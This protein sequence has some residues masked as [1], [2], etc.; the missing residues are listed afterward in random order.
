MFSRSLPRWPFAALALLQMVGLYVMSAQPPDLA[1]RMAP[2]PLGNLLHLPI[3]FI[4]A[5]LVLRAFAPRGKLF[6]EGVWPG[7]RTGA[8]R[9]CLLVVLAHAVFDEVHQFFVGRTCS[10]FDVLMDVT[11]AVILLLLPTPALKDRPAGWKPVVI[12]LSF[13]V[14][15]GIVGWAGRPWPDRLLEQ[16][17]QSIT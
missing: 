1:R 12:A 9:A 5:A 8:G 15:L 6:E 13:G 2:G 7:L 14:V 10:V 11:G 3:Y 4:L 17:L 16:L